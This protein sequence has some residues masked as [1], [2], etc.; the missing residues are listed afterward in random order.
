MQQ[1]LVF[2]FPGC[3]LLWYINMEKQNSIQPKEHVIRRCLGSEGTQ[4]QVHP[5]RDQRKRDRT[6]EN[7]TKR[8]R[9]LVKTEREL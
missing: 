9:T 5:Q 6:G 7:L 3:Q 1:R 8:W 4:E 2:C